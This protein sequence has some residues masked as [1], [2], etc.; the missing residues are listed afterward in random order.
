MVHA[1][2]KLPAWRQLHGLNLMFNDL[3]VSVRYL[4]DVE[5]FTVPVENAPN[6]PNSGELPVQALTKAVTA[7]GF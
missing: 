1:I 4:Y 5:E 3:D 6:T 7:H 2:W